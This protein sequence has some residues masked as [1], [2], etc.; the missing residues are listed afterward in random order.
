MFV[1][2]EYIQLFAAIYTKSM[3]LR[4]I[5]T[6]YHTCGCGDLGFSKYRLGKQETAGIKSGMTH[7]GCTVVVKTQ[8]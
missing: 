5:F 6:R 7:A 1:D 2:W 3:E 8:K 4:A